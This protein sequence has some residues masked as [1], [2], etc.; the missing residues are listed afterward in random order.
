MD[1]INASLLGQKAATSILSGITN[2][3]FGYEKGQIVSVDLID[4]V[5][6]KKVIDPVLYKLAEILS[7]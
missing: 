7:R 6:N 5:R 1:R 2:V 4:A 3:M